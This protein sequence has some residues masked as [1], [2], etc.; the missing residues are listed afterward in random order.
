M[1]SV[2]LHDI[3]YDPSRGAFEARVDV[4]RDDSTFRYPCRLRAPADL[5][6]D[7]V[8]LGLIAQA[9]RMSDT[10]RPTKRPAILAN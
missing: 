2:E 6:Q 5:A 4:T 8:R 7:K 3:Q 1:Q 9:L 10:P